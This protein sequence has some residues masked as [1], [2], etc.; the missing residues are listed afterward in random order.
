MIAAGSPSVAGGRWLVYALGGGAGHWM[1][2]LALS[3]A[4]ARRGHQVTILHNSPAAAG[5]GL[6][7]RWLSWPPSIR[8]V[9]LESHLDR[10][11]CSGRVAAL[12]RQEVFDVLIVD[13]F[14]RG[15]A[16]ELPTLL[17][18]LR[19]FK[20]LIHRDLNPRYAA[21]NQV[22]E[23]CDAYDLI[24][25]PGERGPLS[26]LPPAVFTNPWLVADDWELKTQAQ[27]RKILEAADGQ[28][29]VVV[30]GS[31]KPEEWPVSAAWAEAIQQRLGGL[32]CVRFVCLD[33]AARALAPTLAV[34][35]WPLLVLLPGVDLLVGGGGYNTVCESRATETT[36][37][38]IP[39]PRLY[40]R[41]WRRL[42]PAQ[43]AKADNLLQRVA[44]CTLRRPRPP[45]PPIYQNGVHQAVRLIEESTR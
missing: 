21:R 5:V 19:A 37:L 14:P 1:R 31:G 40:D 7:D 27:S 36:L 42:R 44:A 8:I 6:V 35:C 38:A 3:R 23:S 22:R 45:K 15:L 13:T 24:L 18:E 28:P 30:S 34:H 33:A 11:Q 16:G 12:L 26:D 41:Q 4:A 2:A 39:Q 25:L 43:C 9:G 32:A 10:N 20:V 29:L 17:P